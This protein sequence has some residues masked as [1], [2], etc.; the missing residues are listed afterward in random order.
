MLHTN[1]KLA[2]TKTAFKW[3][4]ELKAHP[5]IHLESVQIMHRNV[6][7]DVDLSN[8]DYDKFHWAYADGINKIIMDCE[9]KK[10]PVKL[11]LLLDNLQNRLF[12]DVDDEKLENTVL[13]YVF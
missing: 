1:D 3:L 6:I 2:T 11:I 13:K 7:K 10:Q 9:V 4:F 5:K 8:I 12:I